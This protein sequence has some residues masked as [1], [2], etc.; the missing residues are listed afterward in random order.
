MS[1]LNEVFE[2]EN[3]YRACFADR[4]L[5]SDAHR[6][7][8]AYK[9]QFRLKKVADAMRDSVQGNDYDYV[10]RAKNLLWA[11]LIQGVLNHPQLDAIV[12]AH[13]NALSV[14]KEFTNV[15]V[16]LGVSKVR[17]IMRKAATEPKYK[18]QLDDDRLG[19]LRTKA[20]YARCMEVADEQEAWTKRAL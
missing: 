9:I 5:K 1:R 20:F 15:L 8:V 2:T 18:E 19:F 17:H 14:Q 10:P 4:Y 13:G 11:L 6:V 7:L 12:A 16:P 3:Q